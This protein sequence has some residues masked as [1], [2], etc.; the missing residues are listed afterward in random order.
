MTTQEVERVR[1]KKETR[2]II[3]RAARNRLFRSGN[4]CVGMTSAVSCLLLTSYLSP[5]PAQ[6]PDLE[7]S[8]RRLDEIRSERQQLE[9]QQ[10]RLQG[11]VSD[12]GATLRNLEK[13]RDATNRLVNVI[14]SQI[15]GL[16]SQLDHSAAELT[17]AQDNLADRKAVLQRRL[18]D[19][20]RRGPLY[21]F[22]VLLAAESFGDL[23]T[24]YKYLFLTSRQDRNLV[25][26]VTK[27]TSNVQ[28]E[29][30]KLLGVRT[31]LDQRKEERAGGDRPLQQARRRPAAT[32][33]PVAAQ[34]AADQTEA[35]RRRE[36][37]GVRSATCWPPS[38]AT[39]APR[40][41]AV[42]RALRP[43][44]RPPS[45]PCPPAISASSTGRSMAT[46]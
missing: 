2:T 13:Q 38:R 46:S 22:Q 7:Q 21:T 31:E 24:R 32:A 4:R 37:R 15:S 18:A 25:E 27:L 1:S 5:L 23:L 34:R 6:Q 33:G 30:D 11:Q 26:D 3:P 41:P 36:G 42:P 16:S 20:Y 39:S 9:R 14:E 35:H 45:A 19:I 43:S 12:V 29:H 44:T 28:K 40:P 8:K 17:L 10:L